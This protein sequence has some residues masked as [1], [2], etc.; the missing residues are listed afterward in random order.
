MQSPTRVI[1]IL[2]I[3]IKELLLVVNFSCYICFVCNKIKSIMLYSFNLHVWMCV[4]LFWTYVCSLKTTKFFKTDEQRKELKTGFKVR[5]RYIISLISVWNYQS[6]FTNEPK[7]HISPESD[8]NP[9]KNFP[10]RNICLKAHLCQKIT[11]IVSSGSCI[12]LSLVW[13]SS[14]PQPVTVTWRREHSRN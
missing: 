7:P 1:F 4:Y 12:V 13:A 3:G 5:L 14:N 11:E 6:I 2:F 10:K 8:L 9:W